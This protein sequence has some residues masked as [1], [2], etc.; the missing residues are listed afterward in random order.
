MNSTHCNCR[1]F[2]AASVVA[3]L[4]A[5]RVL[6]A[7]AA[8]ANPESPP[9]R[10]ITRGPKYHWFGY[11]DK[12]EFDPTNRF[13]L[14]M[15]FGFQNRS[16]KP[17]DR[18]KI[19][20]VDLAEED[21]WIDLGE[22]CA[23]CWQQGCMLQWIPGTQS[24]VLW[25][26]REG[27]RF[28]CRILNVATGD[29]RT[30]PHPIYTIHP[31][32]KTAVSTSFS[33]LADVR[34]GYGYAGVPDPCR[35]DS[36]PADSGIWRVS[37]STGSQELIFSLKEIARFGNSLT[38]MAGAKHWFNHLLFNPDGSRFA[39]LHRWMGPNGRETRLLTA[40]PDGSELRVVDDNGLT[41]HFW[42]RDPQHI[43]LFSNQPSNG[44][45]FCLFE[46]GDRK[47]I[48]VVGPGVMTVDGH[49]SY[50]PGNEWILNDTYPQDGYQY[51]YLYH[52]VTDCKV[53][54]GKFRA[55][56]KY[57]G[58]W[59]CDTHPRISRD[60]KSVV[61]DAADGRNGRQLHLIDIADIVS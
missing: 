15:Q 51:P 26:D 27:D 12:L 18:I 20:M 7:P 4:G 5:F 32:G 37:L 47:S 9:V 16:P 33:R 17:D 57:T 39:F 30:I 24:E 23:W 36:L 14:G 21:R 58:Q 41:S 40:N 28:V 53:S 42:W 44:I 60:G 3:C 2:A 55:P 25:N 1:Q 38:T 48:E 35:D 8:T 34:P 22:S 10:I 56:A 54:L 52:P 50:L 45:R 31:D 46:D 49:C 19:G 13:V 6:N 43:L 29:L 11:Y 59:R 61:I